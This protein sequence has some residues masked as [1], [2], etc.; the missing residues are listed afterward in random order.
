MKRDVRTGKHFII[1][2]NIGR[3]T[4]RSAIAE[5]GGVE[6]LYSAYC[7]ALQ[8]PLP[9]NLEQKYV[10]A[11]WIYLRQ[12]FQSALHHW[13]RGELTLTQWARSWRGHKTDAVFSWPDQAPFWADVT[14]SI[15]LLFR[16]NKTHQVSVFD[17]EAVHLVN[18]T[19]T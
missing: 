11:K 6:M 9:P 14:R 2:P 17:S 12:D 18:R 7:D 1:E 19:V 8:K 10:G 13:R 15:G 5:A 16:K 3:P 4:G